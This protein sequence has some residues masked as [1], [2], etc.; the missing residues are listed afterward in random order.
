MRPENGSLENGS[1]VGAPKPPTDLELMLYL[2][3]ELEEPRATEIAR[4]LGDA[5]EEAEESGDPGEPA[6]LVGA[7]AKLVAMDAVGEVVRR[8][9]EAVGQDFSVADAVMAHV[10]E[11]DR[12]GAASAPKALPIKKPAANDNAVSRR[13]FALAAVAVAAAAA[14][15]VWSRAEAPG[16]VAERPVAP[17]EAPVAPIEAP[18]LANPAEGDEPSE[19][20]MGVVVAAVDFGAHSGSIFYVPGGPSL[21]GETTTV[22]WVADEVPGGE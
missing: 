22:V 20:D 7:R 13:I 19:E 4:F 15:M 1:S 14:M 16:P 8:R 3:G 2:D 9:A 21:P 17:I 10:A 5:P 6:E 11:L 18:E 12:A